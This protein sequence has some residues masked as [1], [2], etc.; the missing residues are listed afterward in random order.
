MAAKVPE[1]LS[2]AVCKELY[3]TPRY[4][5]CYHSYCENCLA[6]IQ[7]DGNITCP[8]CTKKYVDVIPQGGLKEL[9]SDFFVSGLVDERI[10]EQKVKG[11]E[12]V[13]CDGC[14]R[15]DPASVLCRDCGVLLCN[16]CC[17]HH[18]ISKKN[19]GHE[20]VLLKEL[21]EKREDVTVRLKH[22]ALLCNEH[23]MVL[24]IY[25]NTCNQLICLY[26]TNKE[27][28]GHDH[29][30]VK[31]CAI[32]HREEMDQI[33]VPVDMMIDRLSGVCDEVIASSKDIE[34]QEMEISQHID[35]YY[36]QLQQILLRQKAELK[37]ELHKAC[38][39]KTKALSAHLKDTQSTQVQL[40]SIKGLYN[41]TKGGS[42]EGA[43]FVKKQIVDDFRRLKESCSNLDAAP[44]EAATLK[45]VPVKNA[46]LCFPQF[47][48]IKCGRYAITNI[49]GCA[50]V[51]QNIEFNISE[52]EYCHEGK[53]DA[54][55]R[56]EVRSMGMVIPSKVRRNE[57]GGFS[58]SFTS[59]RVG[60]VTVSVTANGL[61]VIGSPCNIKMYESY[62]KVDQ[63]NKMI[64]LDG[65]MGIPWGIASSK[66]GF[67]AVADHNNNKI[68]VFNNQDQLVQ[69]FGSD[70]K[71]DGQFD[72]PYGLA[73]S[74]EN[75]LFVS[76]YHNHRI[77]QFTISGEYKLQFGGK[78]TIPGKL[79]DP[80]GVLVHKQEVYVADQINHRISVFTCGGKFCRTIGSEKQLG[81]PHDMAVN[82]QQQILIANFN[83]DCISVYT[84]NGE[85]MKKIGTKGTGVGHLWA[86]TS[87]AVD[88]YGFLLVTEYLN[89]RVSVFDKD[90]K[91]I[92]CFGSSGPGVNQFIQPRGIAIS[93]TG[94]ILVSDY[95]NKRIQIFSSF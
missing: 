47:G 60:E 17:D 93:A 8:K 6:K 5:P 54:P 18:K 27:H 66:D 31:K 48:I 70:G 79:H 24:E 73:F 52:Q 3:K 71:G 2:C 41:G 19:C 77:Q 76:D 1:H 90:G 88:R 16:P 11:N 36:E 25:C 62:K 34:T 69:T 53:D 72:W 81:R 84:L 12:L 7:Q 23:D 9:P 68:H 30:T 14:I 55:V 51:G 33:M 59:R 50:F 58:A 87:I 86:P 94:S 63:P 40:A 61:P 65:K 38:V 35:M 95:E 37:Q 82:G 4:L 32:T 67:W 13:K 26:C 64:N 44:V 39:Q 28:H 10:I 80:L 21:Q 89:D 91:H 45:F 83:H 78:G 85:Y 57:N 56:V 42:D 49:P 92:H 29:N 43:L 15:N 75:L 22:K 20:I 74:D 46:D